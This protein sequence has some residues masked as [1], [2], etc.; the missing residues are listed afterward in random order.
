MSIFS[1]AFGIDKGGSSLIDTALPLSG[2]GLLSGAM[3]PDD[4]AADAATQAAQTQAAYQQQALDYLKER[5]AVPQAL[6]ESSLQKL[7]WLYGLNRPYFDWNDPEGSMDLVDEYDKFMSEYKPSQDQ[8]I[9][10][11]M[12]SPLYQSLIGGREAGEEAIMRQAG[13]TGGLRSGNVQSNLYDYNT[14][15]ENQA[16]LNAY[17]QQLAENQQQLSGLTGLSG[18]QSYAPQIS[19]GISGIGTTLAQG[20]TAAAQAQQ[21]AQ[22]QGI[23]NLFGAGQLGLTAF[24]MF[25]DRRL[26]KNIRPIGSIK[27]HKMYRWTWNRIGNALGLEGDTIGCLADEVHKIVPEAVTLK[28]GFLYVNYDRIGIFP[29]NEVA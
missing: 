12:A 23:N 28:D 3:S 20:Q 22:Q 21:A 11:A 6:R 17:N 15:L 8:I 18:L 16:L 26:K 4:S 1:K 27:G 25:S 24:S 19:S 5:E 10:E 29:I 9:E 2:F 13:S 7:G 14:Q